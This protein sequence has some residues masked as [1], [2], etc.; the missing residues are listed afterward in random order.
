MTWAVLAISLVSGAT[1]AGDGPSVQRR[2]DDAREHFLTGYYRHAF[3]EFS[4]LA[5]AGDAELAAS[6]VVAMADFQLAWG[7]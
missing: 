1:S 3:E 4:D 6:A 7:D 2:F 5:G